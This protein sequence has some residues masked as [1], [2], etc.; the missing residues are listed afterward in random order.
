MTGNAVEG[1]FGTVGATETFED[2]GAFGA[3]VVIGVAETD[4]RA[5]CGRFFFL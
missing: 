4:D 2:T 5:L 3:A 1:V